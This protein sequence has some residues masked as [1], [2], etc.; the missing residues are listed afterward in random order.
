MAGAA[1]RTAPAPAAR[2]PADLA[3]AVPRGTR[4]PRSGRLAKRLAAYAV[5]LLFA[6]IYLGPFAIQIATSFKTDPD[7]VA[8]PLSLLPHPLSLAAWERI[9]G[10][11]DEASVPFW[12]WLGNSAF[13][14][15]ICTFG[16]VLLDSLAGYALA[17]LDFPG[18]RAVFALV[19]AILAVPNV[20]LL[21]PKF[22]VLNELGIYDTRAAM[23]LPLVMDA[24]GI[25]LMRQFFLQI[26]REMEEAA[27]VDGAGVWRTYWSI[28]LPL[29]RPGLITLTIL[30]FQG[31]WNEFTHFLIAT[32]N[33][34]YETL[35]VGLAR[36]QGGLGEGSQFPLT[37]GAALL[38]TIPVAIVFFLFQRYFIRGQT[39]AAV[40]G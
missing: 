7:A 8:N 40:K 3:G 38:T 33:P 32:S 25:F 31:T 9:F 16:R 36:F 26:P 4:R 23:V 13:V 5:L 17:R 28:I 21:V 37:M 10:F 12:R 34:A 24:T 29:A 14:S 15:V 1:T 18:R 27:R 35:T 30:S 19:I 39:G 22:L 6:A 2:R 20:V 11:S